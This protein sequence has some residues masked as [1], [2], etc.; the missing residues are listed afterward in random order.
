M[1]DHKG[2]CE[3][4]WRYFVNVDSRSIRVRECEHCGR[5]AVVPTQM[6]PMPRP[7]Y[8]EPRLSA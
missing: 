1:E 7:K 5:R 2:P 3:H 6:A 8:L 4:R